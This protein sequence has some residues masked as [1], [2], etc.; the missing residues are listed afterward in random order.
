VVVAPLTVSFTGSQGKWPATLFITPK[1]V[2]RFLSRQKA[3]E[4]FS[5]TILHDH[6][7][8]IPK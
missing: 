5:H 4:D 7:E 1:S 2:R 6:I 8:S 3:C